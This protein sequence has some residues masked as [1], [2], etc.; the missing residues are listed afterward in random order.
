[1][2]PSEYYVKVDD[3][4]R[5]HYYLSKSGQ[6]TIKKRISKEDLQDIEIK[7]WDFVPTAVERRELLNKKKEYEYKL[8]KIKIE[9]E[10]LDKVIQRIDLRLSEIK[11][12][13]L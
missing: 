8:F 3:A 5:K 4:G 12:E 7:P 2:A 10:K 13:S 9:R 11:K 1:M 6:S